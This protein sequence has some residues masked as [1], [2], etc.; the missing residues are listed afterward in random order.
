MIERTQERPSRAARRHGFSQVRRNSAAA[1]RALRRGAARVGFHGV[2]V[3]VGLSV[4]VSAW[5]HPRDPLHL[6]ETVADVFHEDALGEVELP[7]PGVDGAASMVEM[8]AEVAAEAAAEPLKPLVRKVSEGDTVRAIADEHSVSI[9]TILASNQIDD[10][11]MIMPGQELLIPPLD[12]LVAEIEPGETLGQVAERFG[13]EPAEIAQANALSPDPDQAVPY[14]RLVV[15]GLEPAERTVAEPRRKQPTSVAQAAA[16]AEAAVNA[17]LSGLSYEVQEG[18]TLAQLSTQFGVSIWTILT[19]NN[20]ADA[21]MLQPGI[22]LKVPVVNGV[23]HEV[24]T[25]ESLADI[26]S[27]YEV[28]LGPLLDFNAIPDPANVK[29]GSKLTIPGAEKPQPAVSLASIAAPAPVAALPAIVPAPSSARSAARPATESATARQPRSTQD[30]ASAQRPSS[31]TGVAQAPAPKPQANAPSQAA[32]KPQAPAQAAAKPQ[33][34]AQAAAKP[35]APAQAQAQAPN[36]V[37]A[38]SVSAPVPVASGAGGGNVVGA[39]MRHLG[40]RY[41]FGGTSPGGFDCS[42]FMWYVYNSSGKPVSRGLWGMMNAGPRV[43][44]GELQPGDAVFFANTYMPG[45]SHGG[46]YIGGGRFIHA[47]DERSGVKI[48]SMGEGYWSSR[49]VGASRIKQ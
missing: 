20:L 1:R 47:S 19:A 21:D 15:P 44:Q 38:S 43:G 24:Q 35:Q 9:A 7:L 40:S 39:A 25:G 46:I 41:V 8:V 6:R 29:V 45:L 33:A 14:E 5:N 30:T 12:G 27:Y 10:P 26:A 17:R 34:P 49:F 11:D 4:A 22:T 36:R 31:Q 18:D 13:V 28:D 16:E 32:A 37:A 2:V 48:S 3:A 42:G 23:E